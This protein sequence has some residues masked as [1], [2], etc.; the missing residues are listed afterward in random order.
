MQTNIEAIEKYLK[1]CSVAYNHEVLTNI[2]NQSLKTKA[3]LNNALGLNS[4]NNWRRKLKTLE[5]PESEIKRLF[6]HCFSLI[7]HVIREAKFP[8]DYDSYHNEIEN[9]NFSIANNRFSDGAKISRFLNKAGKDV[10]LAEWKNQ[11]PDWR[12]TLCR[13]LDRD[14]SYYHARKDF[15]WFLSVVFDKIKPAKSHRSLY[16]STNPFDFYGANADCSYSSCYR[17]DGEYANSTSS[18]LQS[19]NTL[20]V[21][22][23]E[24]R[25]SCEFSPDNLHKIGRSWLHVKDQILWHTK[26]YGSQDK[27]SR[28][29]ARIFVKNAIYGNEDAF[30]VSRGVEFN[31]T[32]RSSRSYIDTYGD[33]AY[34]KEKYYNSVSSAR[35]HLGAHRLIF[36]DPICLVCGEQHSQNKRHVCDECESKARWI[37][38]L[39]EATLNPFGLDANPI[40]SDTRLVEIENAVAEQRTSESVTPSEVILEAG[41]LPSATSYAEVEAR[42][43]SE[44]VID[45]GTLTN[46]RPF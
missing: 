39:Q 3:G 5:Q 36:A 38:P 13:E 7:W 27:T 25:T 10:L 43:G 33:F 14:E 19:P 12:R 34:S 31:D 22:T 15:S 40:W 46:T 35:S 37:N 2:C 4:S 20:A 30:K 9:A 44:W 21:I 16:L 1:S 24:E 11:S 18:M 8:T 42:T 28:Q 32:L 45:L 26:S 41:A 6:P 23:F 17:A 29:N